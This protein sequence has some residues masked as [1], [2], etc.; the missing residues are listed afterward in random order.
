MKGTLL[1]RILVLTVID[2]NSIAR[3]LGQRAALQQLDEQR[4]HAVFIMFTAKQRT[5]ANLFARS[6]RHCSSRFHK[7][8]VMVL[9]FVFVSTI[10]SS[11]IKK[12]NTTG[13]GE[14]EQPLQFE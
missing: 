3:R 8:L 7:D 9:S 5:S 2:I 6:Y 1:S 13:M 12:A 11:F 10:L 4:I 14:K